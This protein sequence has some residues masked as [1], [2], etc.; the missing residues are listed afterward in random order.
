MVVSFL[1]GVSLVLA[2]RPMPIGWDDLGVYM[3]FPRMMALSGSLL[4]G[5]GMYTWQL[6]TST[7][8]LWN[9]IATQ[10]FYVNQLGGILSMII[11][12][13]VLSALFE[14]PHKKYF[15]SLPVIL[16][17]VYY[18][19]PMTI[20]QQAKDMKLDPALMAVSVSA[21]GLLWYTLRN[22]MEKKGFWITILVAGCIVGLAFSIKFTT[23][24]FVIAALGYIAYHFIGLSGFL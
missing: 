14:F 12:I 3:N 23:L 13:S 22:H 19:M 21:F 5:A 20:F 11:I 1:I 17:I 24:M 16:G 8:Y 4:Q 2:I 10:A 6:I 15:L 9:D 7:G 18:F